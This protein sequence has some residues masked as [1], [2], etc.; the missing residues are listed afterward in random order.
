MTHFNMKNDLEILVLLG[1][2]MSLV[3]RKETF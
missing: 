3:A 1:K 2:R